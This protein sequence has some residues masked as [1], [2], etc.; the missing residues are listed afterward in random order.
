VAV[1]L[2]QVNGP[3]MLLDLQQINFGD[4][5]MRRGE[6]SARDQAGARL[7]SH[8]LTEGAAGSQDFILAK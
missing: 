7:C 5:L 3:V 6:A 1:P 8:V 2:L 4:G